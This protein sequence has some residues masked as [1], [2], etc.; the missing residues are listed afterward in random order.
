MYVFDFWTTNLCFRYIFI[1]FGKNTFK[2]LWESFLYLIKNIQ[3]PKSGFHAENSLQINL[4]Y[5]IEMISAFL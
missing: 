5:M 3:I 4:R 1:T 2:Q